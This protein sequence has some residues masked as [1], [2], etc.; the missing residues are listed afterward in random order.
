MSQILEAIVDAPN[1]TAAHAILFWDI[2]IGVGNMID[3]IIAKCQ[4]WDFRWRYYGICENEEQLQWLERAKKDMFTRKILE[5]ELELS[6]WKALPKEQP[7]EF[8]LEPPL[9]P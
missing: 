9:E 2:N 1:L 7:K 5:G 6:G 3:S 8:L 4:K